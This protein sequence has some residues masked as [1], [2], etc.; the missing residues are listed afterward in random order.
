[1]N[2]PKISIITVSYNAVS[3][4]ERTI[5]SVI[6]QDYPNKEYIIIDGHS[7][8][9]TVEI[10]KRFTDSI[11]FW[12]SEKDN[13]IYDA[14]NKGIKHA[15]GDI[16]GI[17]NSDDYYAN[18]ALNRIA[19]EYTKTRGK[20]IIHG[21]MIFCQEGKERLFIPSDKLSR[22]W[23]GQIVAHPTVFVPRDLYL[24]FGVFNTQY[25]IAADY[26]L[27]LRFYTNNVLFTHIKAVI[28][29][30][31]DGGVSNTNRIK[32]YKEVKSIAL[33]SKSFSTIKI[34]CAFIYNTFVS[35]LIT[36][37]NYIKR[38]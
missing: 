22:M 26:D 3:T 19:A 11:T 29:Y 12:V 20:H 30:M 9:G 34:E 18:N 32:G 13:G 15:T 31:S 14:M 10:I 8:D 35:T 24:K 38:H 17:I 23:L 2:I 5:L 27:M 6:S 7:T 28:S 33:N 4:I 16:I 37:K 21:N 1:M 36:L 25:K